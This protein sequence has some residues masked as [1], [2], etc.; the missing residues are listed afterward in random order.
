MAS[1]KYRAPVLCAIA[2]ALLFLLFYVG[3]FMPV[4]AEYA[5]IAALPS[6][7]LTLFMDET[8]RFASNDMFAGIT[9]LGQPC[10]TKEDI[11]RVLQQDYIVGSQGYGYF[12]DAE[13]SLVLKLGMDTHFWN[14]EGNAW[15]SI[16]AYT[17][18]RMTFAHAGTP[19]WRMLALGPVYGWL[20]ELSPSNSNQAGTIAQARYTFLHETSV[21]GEA[22]SP[23]SVALQLALAITLYL[24][25]L[26]LALLYRTKKVTRIVLGTYL[27]IGIANTIYYLTHYPWLF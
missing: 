16:D 6:H 1:K 14:G 10:K 15:F 3:Y 5:N 7:D 26:I 27:L 11:M 21:N 9:Y 2:F 17:P 24:L 8:G 12:Y 18:Y 13:H 22:V 4:K 23:L 25:P 20:H 19:L